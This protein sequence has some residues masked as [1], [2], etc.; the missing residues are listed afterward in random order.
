MA[1]EGRE[2]RRRTYT[3]VFL[4]QFEGKRKADDLDVRKGKK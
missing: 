2:Q 4:G 1:K 3:K